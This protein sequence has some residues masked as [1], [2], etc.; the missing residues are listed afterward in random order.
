LV[1]SPCAGLAGTRAQS[2]DWYGSDTLHPGQV[3]RRSL[4]L[5]SLRLDV[6]T[7]V[8]RCLHVLNDERDPSS[9]RWNYGREMSG[10]FAYMASQFTPLGIFHMPQIYDMGR[11]VLPPLRRKAC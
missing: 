3:L 2:G 9:E 10:N 8:A 11:A 4:P 1:F 7:F 6:P 5:L